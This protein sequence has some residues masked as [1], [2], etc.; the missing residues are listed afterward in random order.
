MMDVR[1]KFEILFNKRIQQRNIKVSLWDE[2]DLKIL[3]L[4]VKKIE[5][6]I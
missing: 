1:N 3:R 5:L 2:D 4:F 6:K